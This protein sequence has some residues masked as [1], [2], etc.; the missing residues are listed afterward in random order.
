VQTS[1]HSA[2]EKLSL[3]KQL[4]IPPDRR[5]GQG[6]DDFLLQVGVPDVDSERAVYFTAG[7]QQQVP[8]VSFA[9]VQ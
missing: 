5:L 6:E 7:L 4:N 1:T 9:K 2:D 8:I 3:F